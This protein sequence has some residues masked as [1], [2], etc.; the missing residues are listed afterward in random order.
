MLLL[1]LGC[2]TQDTDDAL[3]PD[4][5][6]END[7][8]RPF[9]DHQGSTVTIRGTVQ[10]PSDGPIDVD[11]W[12]PDPEAPGGVSPQRKIRLAGPGEFSLS[13]PVGLG[14]LE[15]QAFQSGGSE[16]PSSQTPFASA[17]L[18]VAETDLTVAL[19][20]AVGAREGRVRLEDGNP[21]PFDCTPLP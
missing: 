2:T 15:L 14:K 12:V 20:L 9:S 5:S 4:L 21:D 8:T 16:G 18:E 19:V 17:W 1:L 3:A 11:V 7:R 13:A 6:T 10:A